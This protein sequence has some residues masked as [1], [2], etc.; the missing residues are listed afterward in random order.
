MQP[1][2]FIF[3]KD[4]LLLA[5]QGEKFAVPTGEEAPVGLSKSSSVMEVGTMDDGTPIKTFALSSPVINDTAFE[6]IDLRKS[7]HLLPREHYLK[8]GKCRELIY[9]DSNTQYC[10]TCG[11]PLHMHTPISKRCPQC[12]REIWP[13]LNPAIIVLVHKGN[14]AL[15]VHARNFKGDY[16]GLV[17]GFVETG[18]TLEEAVHRE[19]K[20]ET[21]IEI[22]NL[23]YFGSQPWP[24]PCG[25]MVGFNADYD[26]G[27]IHLQQSELSKGAWFTKDNLP[28]I[29][30]PL[31]IA[32]MILDD[33][34]NK[35]SI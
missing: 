21:G 17:A 22:K 3:Y 9:W 1:L 30:E 10:G 28:T 5:K 29:P 14:E 2:W 16:Y 19:V 20:E 33:W 7:F 15:L 13:A 18:E 6:W 23:R 8:A 4:K 25:L 32:R 34:I 11:T 27:D 35:T 24:Y 31:S 26:G 12:G